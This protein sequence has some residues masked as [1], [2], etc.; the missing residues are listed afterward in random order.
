MADARP[1]RGSGMESRG[2]VS[3]F[4]QDQLLCRQGIQSLLFRDITSQVWAVFV[5]QRRDRQHC[6]A[7]ESDHHCAPKATLGQ[8]TLQKREKQAGHPTKHIPSP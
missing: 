6:N 4:S 5:Q 7:D 1:N 2:Q 3:R 8:Y